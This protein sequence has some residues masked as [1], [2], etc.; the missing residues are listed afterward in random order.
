MGTDGF[1]IG[2]NL[3]GTKNNEIVFKHLKG[4]CRTP[5]FPRAMINAKSTQETVAGKV[6][7]LN[8]FS[9][10]TKE[11]NTEVK[12]TLKSKSCS[13]QLQSHD[14]YSRSTYMLLV[15]KKWG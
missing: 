11:K 9:N 7:L 14:K 12:I 4:L 8:D 10:S 2:E 3:R 15:S 13:K 1:L 6:N 5:N